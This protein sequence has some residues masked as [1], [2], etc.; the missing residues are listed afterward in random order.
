MFGNHWEEGRGSASNADSAVGIV[1]A[2]MRTSIA[3]YTMKD[4]LQSVSRSFLLIS[5]SNNYMVL[6]N[7]DIIGMKENTEFERGK[8]AELLL[9][10]THI[11][12]LIAMWER[13]VNKD[14]TI[15]LFIEDLKELKRR[16]VEN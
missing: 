3:R 9:V 15:L 6:K 4:Q 1:I 2:W 7:V 13:C 16:I 11:D 8:D 12:D 5:Y 10:L 14:D